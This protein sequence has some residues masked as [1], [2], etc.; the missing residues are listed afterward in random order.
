MGT[1]AEKLTYLNDTKDKLK[2][3]INAMGGEIDD[4]SFRSYPSTLNNL[5]LQAINGEI[6]LYDEY[7]KQQ[8][9]GTSFTINNTE[10]GKAEIQLES[11]NLTQSSTP[12]P[13][14][15]VPVN[16]ISGNNTITISNNDTDE[17][18]IYP[19]NLGTLEICKIGNYA[20][21]IYFTDGN[22]YK[23]QKIKKIV[24]NG[25]QTIAS[26]NTSSTNTTRVGF[27]NIASGSAGS[28]LFCNQLVLKNNWNTDVEGISY[29]TSNSSL[30]FRILKTTIGTTQSEV[31]DYLSNNNI[32]VYIPLATAT[33]I[34]ITDVDLISNLNDIYNN[35]KSLSG[36]TIINQT[37][38]GLPFV[39]DITTLDKLNV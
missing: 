36:E 6:D 32:I 34:L 12:T 24:L 7:P 14:N 1:T 29:N 28:S 15:P 10:Y 20:D 13:I 2:T 26:V 9:T 25:T 22:W 38:E 11:N 17:S 16:V 30:W 27:S 31:N 19:I 8:A 33:D 21:E 4:E 39:I 18:Q 23:K 37:N 35:V 3:V 5:V